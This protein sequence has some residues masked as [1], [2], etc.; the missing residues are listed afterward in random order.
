MV[1]GVR[2]VSV[3]RGY[4]CR[5]FVFVGPAARPGPT[6]PHRA[7]ARPR[8][9]IVPPSRPHSAWGML[10]TDLRFEVRAPIS[11]TPAR[12]RRRRQAPVRGHRSRGHAAAARLVRRSGA[13]QPLGICVTANRC[14]RS[15][16]RST[17]PVDWSVADPLPQN[18]EHFTGATRRSTPI[19]PDKAAVLVNS[20]VRSPAFLEE[21][22]AP[23]VKG[24]APRQAAA[25]SGGSTSAATARRRST[26]SKLWRR[27]TR[28][29]GRRSSSW[30]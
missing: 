30:R 27:R 12:S 6:P 10:A 20:R 7:P 16:C 4:H 23:R 13:G 9:V 26:D 28:S 17:T 19:E 22:R 8:R 29:E 21:L 25:A 14:S 1:N 5:R 24:G 15:P 2:L 18:V 3:H 11:A